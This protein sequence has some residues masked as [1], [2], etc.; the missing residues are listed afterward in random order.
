MNFTDDDV[1]RLATYITGHPD[2]KPNAQQLA[3]TR[4]L[5]G[6]LVKEGLPA[7]VETLFG[8]A[9]EEGRTWYRALG[10]D[11]SLWCETSNPREAADSTRG[12]DG[13]TLQRLPLY[14]VRTPWEA[15]TP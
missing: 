14:L 13:Y 4:A 2:A 10:P 15:W 11:G 8:G 7:L 5:L 3:A 6:G 12:E 9:S 1:T